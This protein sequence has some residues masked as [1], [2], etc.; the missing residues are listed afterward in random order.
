MVFFY[1]RRDVICCHWLNL[2]TSRPCIFKPVEKLTFQIQK[3]T[4]NILWPLDLTLIKPISTWWASAAWRFVSGSSTYKC[5]FIRYN[6]DLSSNILDS[7]I[8][9]LYASLALFF[10]NSTFNFCSIKVFLILR[11][12]LT[13]QRLA[14]NYRTG[15]IMRKLRSFNKG[16]WTRQLPFSLFNFHQIARVHSIQY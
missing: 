9:F 15:I 5:Y 8:F 12:L 7:F 2:L 3:A 4:C 6:L 16:H 10:K 13:K 11:M 14:L 1:L